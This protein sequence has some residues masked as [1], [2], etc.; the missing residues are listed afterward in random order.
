[1]PQYGSLNNMLDAR[2][3]PKP[4]FQVGDGATLLSY[5]DRHAATIVE[6]NESRTRVVIQ[7]DHAKRV[8]KNG[9]SETQVYEY[10]P[11]PEAARLVFTLRKDGTFKLS[12]G[13]QGVIIGRREEYRDFTR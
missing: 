2:M 10:T 7:M 8:D 5:S 3:L 11:N 4:D 12:G 1:M 6:I 13:L 9:M